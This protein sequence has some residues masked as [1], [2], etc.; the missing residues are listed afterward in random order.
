MKRSTVISF[1]ALFLGLS[2]VSGQGLTPANQAFERG[3]YRTAIMLYEQLIADQKASADLLYNLGNA[4]YKHNEIGKAILNYERCLKLE[5]G[6][7]PAQKNIAFIKDQIAYPFSSIPE[8]FLKRWWTNLVLFFSISTWTWL[9]LFSLVLGIL[10]LSSW[11]FSQ[12]METKKWGFFIGTGSL[13][14]SLLFF[15]LADQRRLQQFDS[16]EGI[17][18]VNKVFLK[19]APDEV[20]PDLIELQEGVKVFIDD[21]LN[22]WYKVYLEDRESGWIQKDWIEVI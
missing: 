19:T 1:L 10:G 12:K 22:E 11:L 7:E 20:S 21:E 4:Y 14:I 18:L 13:L 6:H 17:V 3:D 16:G 8:F 15:I 2:I 9:H 5:P